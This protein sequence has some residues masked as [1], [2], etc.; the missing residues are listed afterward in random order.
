MGQIVYHLDIM[1]PRKRHFV[2]PS[3]VMQARQRL[4]VDPVKRVFEQTQGL[5]HRQPPHPHWCGLTLLGVDGVGV[6]WRPNS[7]ENQ[8]AFAS[9]RNAQEEAS[10]PQICMVCQMGLTPEL[11][12][13]TPDDSL[14]L[15]DRGF[16][17]LGG[18]CMLG[19]A[20]EN[21]AIGRLR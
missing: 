13:N 21:S 14:T 5:W 3:A 9:T 16:Y 4:G 12:A 8:A 15:F 19:G 2:A 20:P 10:S 17:S 18:C 1:L 7:P 6:V 11:I